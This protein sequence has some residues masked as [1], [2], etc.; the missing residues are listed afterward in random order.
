MPAAVEC[1]F[2]GEQMKT[3]MWLALNKMALLFPAK[4]VAEPATVTL[5]KV[6]RCVSIANTGRSIRG[7]VAYAM[8]GV[9]GHV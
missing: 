8:Q 4:P 1:T 6:S 7:Q 9:H 3:F 5:D 2:D